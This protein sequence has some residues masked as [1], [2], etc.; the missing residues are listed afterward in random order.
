M[1]GVDCDGFDVRADG[2]LLRF[3][4]ERPMTDAADARASLVAL[5][6]APRA[7]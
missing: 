3:G 7:E 5:A 4:F 2:Q 1:V 6:R